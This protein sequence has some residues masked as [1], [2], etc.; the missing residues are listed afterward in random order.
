[1]QAVDFPRAAIIAGR[2]DV[3]AHTGSTNADLLAAVAGEP[4]AYPHLSVLV[5]DD[6]RA[7][8]GRLDRTWTAPA[9]AALAISVLVRVPGIRTERRGWVPLIAGAAMTLAIRGLFA[10]PNEGDG[11]RVALKWPNDVLI[12]GAKV[13]GILSQMVPGQ[14]DAIVVGAGVNTLMTPE[15]LPVPTAT[16][17]AIAGAHVDADRLLADYLSALDRMLAAAASADAFAR[18]RTEVRGVCATLGRQV[19]VMLPDERTLEGRATGL[20]DAGRLIVAVG[21]ESVPVAAGDV[22]HVR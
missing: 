22:I 9:G 5:T 3:V 1:M 20:D 2:L 17:L 6:Q 8:R 12:D 16:S 10:P 4:D 18:V 13:C 15:Q 19:R 7:G 14:P 11:S 21:G